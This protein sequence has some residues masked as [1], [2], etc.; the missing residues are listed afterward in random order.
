MSTSL[1]ISLFSFLGIL[2]A[3]PC[4]AQMRAVDASQVQTDPIA[5][6]LTAHGATVE[7]VQRLQLTG[8]STSTRGTELITIS[9]ALDG[10]V[11]VEYGRPATRTYLGT[12]KATTEMVDGKLRFKPPQV[13]AFAQL[14]LLAV[15]GIR[16][17]GAS[18]VQRTVQGS[19]QIG[20]R[21]FITARAVTGR[22]RNVLGRDIADTA[23]VKIDTQTG[24]VLEIMRDLYAENSV[25]YSI[26]AGFRFKDYR[27]VDG[28]YMPFQIE[29]VLN[30]KVVET[31]ALDAVDLHASFATDFFKTPQSPRRENVRRIER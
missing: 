8:V 16:H 4:L 23:S 21:T 9:G 7:S 3:V 11:K 12:P 22:Q 10:S 25:E 18:T 20:D 6:A 30:N 2:L 5:A 15:F 26:P 13:G 19:G 17:F 24:V 29:R 1:R 31:I 28:I 14:D 27:L